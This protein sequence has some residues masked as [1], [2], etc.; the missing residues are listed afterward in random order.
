MCVVKWFISPGLGEE[1]E[2]VGGGKR[3]KD[4]CYK[5]EVSVIIS[6]CII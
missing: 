4:A 2:G 5:K 6:L 1:R 3:R